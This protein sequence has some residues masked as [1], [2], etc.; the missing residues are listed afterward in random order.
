[1]PATFDI[2]PRVARRPRS[3]RSAVLGAVVALAAADV[4]GAA[5]FYVHASLGLDSNPGSADRPFRSLDKLARVMGSGDRAF[6]AGEFRE[7][8]QLVGLSNITVAQ[9]PGE[10]QAVLRGDHIITGPWSGGGG[11]WSTVFPADTT[12]AAVVVDWD[13]SIDQDGRHFGFLVR[14]PDLQ[15]LMDNVNSFCF[16]DATGTLTIN[17]DG[18]DPALHQIAYC[19]K[20]VDGLAI[21]GGAS[22]VSGVVVDGIHSYLWGDP[23]P[24]RGY[25]F[26]MQDCRDSVLRNHVAI[27]NGYHGTGWVNY[28]VP[29]IGNL[30]EHGSVWGANNDS[31]YVFYTSV[32]EVSGARWSDCVARKYTFLGRNGRPAPG[33]RCVAFAVHTSNDGPLVKDVMIERCKVIEYA[34]ENLGAAYASQSTPLPGDPLDWR[35][36]PVRVVE[37]AVVG[38]KANYIF[39][40]SMALV[41][42]RLDYSNT[43]AFSGTGEAV[44]SDNAMSGSGAVLLD[45]CEV[46]TNLDGPGARAFFGIR[47][48]MRWIFLNSSFLDAGTNS[49]AHRLFMWY[50]PQA[51]V[52]ARGSIFAF[53]DRAGTRWFGYNDNNAA[54]LGL[55]DFED[56]V[57]VNVSD[58]AYSTVS[59]GSYNDKA[60]WATL[61]DPDGIYLTQVPFA[62]ASGA[63]GLALDPGGPLA[64]L[65]K[66]LAIATSRGINGVAYSGTY[67]AYQEP[68]EADLNND[69]F[70][71][72]DDYDVFAEM[73]ESGDPGADVNN[74]GFVNGDD[75]DIFAGVFESGC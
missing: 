6:L 54:W 53:R 39:P 63:G 34:D 33:A 32:G 48:Q 38:G 44:F 42:C 52:Q 57:Y 29:N 74:D 67:G 24:G 19:E 45:A 56:C 3:H 10:P 5:D 23:T 43:G 16:D 47:G 71:N 18:D 8:L 70:V 12:P 22:G 59:N 62:D 64:G 1:M 46:V 35:T 60:E 31:C 21:I 61:V 2:M 30:E 55:H 50:S 14:M 72:G 37:S 27:D 11:V 17:L 68:C 15:S 20:G 7:R 73:F 40:S 75:I 28:N 65:R 51:G 41:R 26:K 36:Y 49:L 58:A 66:R 25:G 69:G 9:W 4:E 13:A